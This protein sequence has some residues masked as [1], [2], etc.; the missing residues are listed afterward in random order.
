MRLMDFSLNS[1]LKFEKL[2]KFL[3]S[4]LSLV[5]E[6]IQKNLLQIHYLTEI[7]MSMGGGG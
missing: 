2:L 7:A 4:V 5:P 3:V 1:K 6:P